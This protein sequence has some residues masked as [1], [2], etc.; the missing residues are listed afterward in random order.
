MSHRGRLRSALYIAVTCIAFLVARGEM[1]LPLEPGTTWTYA[2]AEQVASTGAGAA[3]AQSDFIVRVA[4]IE[5][6]DG[7][8]LSKIETLAGDVVTKTELWEVSDRGI[9]CY[10]RSMRGDEMSKINP[11]ETLLPLPLKDGASW[12]T[13]G[14]AADMQMHQRFT[15][16]GQE[17]IYV[18][19]GKFRAYHIHCD[20]VA[21]T[22]VS[23]DRW[24]VSGVGFVRDVTTMRGPG[25]TLLE[26]STIE[27]AKKPELLPL[28]TPTPS[29]TPEAASSIEP[30]A[31]PEEPRAAGKRLTV[32][33]SGDPSG[34]LQTEFQS[35]VKS[36]YVRWHGHGLPN[37]A[38]VKVAW[39]AEDV[40]GLVDP[41]FIVD[42]TESVAPSPEANA[43]F[44]LG[45]PQ[46]GWAEGK[47]RVEF[48]VNGELEQTV[49]VRITG[50]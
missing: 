29:P 35:D 22:A 43:R 44:T 39:I 6:I 14:V 4:G 7:K 42:E 36:I 9:L 32:E 26:K 12:E 41:N 16:I 20:G 49:R 5:T 8:A 25:G 23:I 10:G 45:R 17:D 40:G 34:G 48:Y 3:T 38:K 30:T 19:A 11:P 47:Y 2:H 1:P 15:V 31:T 27:L 28:P 46:D 13:D 18:P 24:F 21:L 37:G 50:K 33:V